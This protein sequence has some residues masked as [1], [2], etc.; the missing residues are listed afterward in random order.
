[1]TETTERA[2]RK[3]RIGV[4][5]SDARDKTVTVEIPNLFKHPRYDKVVRRTTKLA[6]HDES[7]DAH[8]GDTVRI[9]ETRPLS[10]QKRW[11]IDEIVE[12]AR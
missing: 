11:R 10:K 1:M 8:V 3:T 5:I 7:N 9:V 2:R 6:V 12:R 4:V